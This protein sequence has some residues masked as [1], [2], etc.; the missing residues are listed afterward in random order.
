MNRERTDAEEVKTLRAR[1]AE[2]ERREP[3]KDKF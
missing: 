3:E 2:F 1:I